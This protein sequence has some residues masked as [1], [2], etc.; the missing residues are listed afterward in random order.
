MLLN[1]ENYK[2]LASSMYDNPS[3]FDESELLYDLSRPRRIASLLKRHSSGKGIDIRLIINHIIIFRNCFNK[4]SVH[5]LAMW[6][7]NHLS[8][9]CA[10]LDYLGIT[11]DV[12]AFDGR[13]IVTD[14]I[15]RSK[16]IEDLLKK[17]L[18]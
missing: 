8:V 18:N 16:E 1:R 4:D 12:F 5:M 2:Q 3:C 14:A 13:V 11:P 7:E 6:N 10:I 15:Q 17:E 9:L